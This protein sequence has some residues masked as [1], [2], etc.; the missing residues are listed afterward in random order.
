MNRFF[1]SLHTPP[2]KRW[3]F[4]VHKYEFFTIVIFN[5]K[6][7]LLVIRDI[8]INDRLP[9][10]SWHKV[11]VWELAGGEILNRIL[12]FFLKNKNF[13]NNLI[14]SFT[15]IVSVNTGK[16][17]FLHKK[18]SI[19]IGVFFNKFFLLNFYNIQVIILNFIFNIRYNYASKFAVV[20]KNYQTIVFL[21][22][23]ILFLFT[24]NTSVILYKALF[25]YFI[26]LSFVYTLISSFIFLNKSYSSGKYTTQVQRFWKRSYI[27]FWLIEIFL[28]IFFSYL[29]LTHF[30]ESFY[31]L[32]YKPLIHGFFFESEYWLA[33][34]VIVFLCILLNYS[35]L[36]FLKNNDTYKIA[37]LFFLINIL[38]LIYFYNDFFIF[39]YTANYYYNNIKN[40]IK[41]SRH[42]IYYYGNMMDQVIKTRTQMH[43]MALITFL[44]FW[45]TV[46][47]YF[48]Y[49]FILNKFL[50]KEISYDLVSSN[51][52][53]FIFLLNFNLIVWLF[54][55]K[56]TVMFFFTNIYFW[57]FVNIDIKKFI[58]VYYE[59]FYIMDNIMVDY[60]Y[61]YK[62]N[63]SGIEGDLGFKNLE[64][65]IKYLA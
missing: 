30:K 65:K 26:L 63:I 9:M 31:F 56:S 64:D 28:F 58:F 21:L 3:E 5:N 57:F 40:Y 60:I 46:F 17:V 38:L 11:L 20:N 35:I 39:F 33:Q 19:L 52:Q 10:L 45:H 53:N 4:I 12:V 47:I 37:L 34:T 24:A 27:L 61:D 49:L 48:F 16:L 41:L 29:L 6:A 62:I 54:L 7:C 8:W 44:K 43:Y 18:T 55:F 25:K 2:I 32:D 13:F 14:K 23:L 22:I 42:A 36:I 59:L 50:K 51:L 15:K 1:Y